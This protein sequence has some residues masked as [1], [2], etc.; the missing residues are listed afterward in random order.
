MVQNSIGMTAEGGSSGQGTWR[1]LR[2][3]PETRH[4]RV[5]C[6]TVS[7]PVSCF[8]ATRV[9]VNHSWTAV[10]LSPMKTLLCFL[11]HHQP[12]ASSA[13]SILPHYRPERR[14]GFHAQP[15]R[16]GTTRVAPIRRPS[17]TALRLEA[18]W[19]DRRRWFQQQWD[20]LQREH[21]W[22]GLHSAPQPYRWFSRPTEHLWLEDLWIPLQPEY[23]W[24][25]LHGSPRLHWPVDA[26]RLEALRHDEMA[27]GRAR[28]ARSTA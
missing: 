25:G 14:R 15:L 3:I 10:S 22:H 18:L 5:Q 6:A 24:H 19:H 8:S 17:L 4:L 27:A 12:L 7:S 1:F 20:G 23:R 9:S 26:R 2:V 28:R 21:R 16:D 13:P 11:A